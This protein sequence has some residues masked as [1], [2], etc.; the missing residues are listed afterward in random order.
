MGRIRLVIHLSVLV[1]LTVIMTGLQACHTDGLLQQEKKF[2]ELFRDFDDNEFYEVITDS[3]SD[4]NIIDDRKKTN[5]A[6]I[7]D[8]KKNPYEAGNNE[9]GWI[10]R[11]RGEKVSDALI[12]ELKSGESY[13]LFTLVNILA[14]IPSKERDAAFIEILKRELSTPGD[15]MRHSYVTTMMKALV[16]NSSADSISTVQRYV[17]DPMQAPGIRAEARVTLNIFGLYG[18]VRNDSLDLK[19]P[20]KSFLRISETS[21]SLISDIIRI[22]LEGEFMTMSNEFPSSGTFEIC[23]IQNHKT[24]I[25][26][27][28]N[29]P[30]DMGT[31]SL[32]IGAMVNGQIPIYYKWITGPKSAAGYIGV[33]E[34]REDQ[35]RVIFW[36]NIWVS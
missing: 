22:L 34:K 11:S 17:N 16:L 21:L 6:L 8:L 4:S 30:S 10:L 3:Y 27:E 26:I 25:I 2:I 20:E 14:D 36:Q 33:L 7:E 15:H 13:Y 29:L 5:E 31:W 23:S 1:M 28:G 9:A 32:E 24:N 12:N 19:L 18:Y 35:W